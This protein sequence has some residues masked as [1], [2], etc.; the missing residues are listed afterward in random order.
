M[1]ARNPTGPVGYRSP[2]RKGYADELQGYRPLEPK[3]PLYR[4]L[5]GVY[6]RA[7]AKIASLPPQ[8]HGLRRAAQQKQQFAFAA[9]K[10]R[11]EAL[12][13]AVTP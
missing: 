3:D 10:Q 4:K 8:A 2:G 13:G 1:N 7:T 6:L 11:F 5:L 9:L 12:Y